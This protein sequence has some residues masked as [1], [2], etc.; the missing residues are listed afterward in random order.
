MSSGGNGGLAMPCV[1]C[2]DMCCVVAAVIA[3]AVA[4]AVALT[5]TSSNKITSVFL[6][7]FLRYMANFWAVH[8]KSMRLAA[9]SA[10]LKDTGEEERREGG[11]ERG[12]EGTENSVVS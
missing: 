3:T 8:K 10:F 5:R 6:F 2:V 4:A 12:K 7:V 9:K 1:V 11:K